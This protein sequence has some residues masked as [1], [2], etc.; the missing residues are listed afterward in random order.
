M[1]SLE[2]LINFIKLNDFHNTQ[3]ILIQTVFIYFDLPFKRMYNTNMM[4]SDKTIYC[5]NVIESNIRAQ[6]Q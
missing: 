4:K 6:C 2:F 3:P 5:Y 1:D